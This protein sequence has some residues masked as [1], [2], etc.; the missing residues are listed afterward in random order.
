MHAPIPRLLTV[1]QLAERLGIRIHQARYLIARTGTK[2]TANAGARFVYSDND[3]VA[4]RAALVQRR[5][6]KPA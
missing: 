2:P 4:L 3:L 1:G 6:S 5:R